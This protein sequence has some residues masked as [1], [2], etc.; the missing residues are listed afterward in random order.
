MLLKKASFPLP[1]KYKNSVGALEELLDI[2]SKAT[3]M[4]INILKHWDVLWLTDFFEMCYTT[5]IASNYLFRTL[6]WWNYLIKVIWFT[7]AKNCCYKVFLWK[8]IWN[9]TYSKINSKHLEPTITAFLLGLDFK[10][11]PLIVEIN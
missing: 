10:S 6:Y 8:D 9:I 11:M 3:F 2:L 1:I 4:D 7:R 5:R